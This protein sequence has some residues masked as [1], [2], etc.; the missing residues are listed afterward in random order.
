[1]L[2]PQAVLLVGHGSVRVSSDQALHSAVDNLNSSMRSEA[3][4]P[5]LPPVIG[6]F[7]NY[8][9]PKLEDVFANLAQQ[10]IKSIWIQPYFLFGGQYTQN[11]LPK[12]V[13]GLRRVWPTI[14]V[15]IGP[16]IAEHPRWTGALLKLAKQYLDTS[17]TRQGCLF[18]V[19]GSSLG[20]QWLR[21][22]R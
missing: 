5:G 3:E 18:V 13:D 12:R 16:V 21:R 15:D 22:C 8:G 6:C 17:V 11:D 1:M 19:H 4:T 2:Q 9:E 14:R 20:Q 7:L 10:G